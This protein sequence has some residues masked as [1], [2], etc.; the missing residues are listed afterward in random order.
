MATFWPDGLWTAEL[1]RQTGVSKRRG[2]L[3]AGA[4][5]KESERDKE[6]GVGEGRK[7]S[8]NDTIG[9]FA[10]NVLNIILLADI[11]GNLARRRR[12]IGGIRAGHVGFGL[13]GYAQRFART[14]SRRRRGRKSSK[15]LMAMPSKV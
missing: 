14:R 13:A 10:N 5:S 3:S 15:W 2:E 8:P 11:E 6:R 7:S 1:G 4:R 9:A 12:V